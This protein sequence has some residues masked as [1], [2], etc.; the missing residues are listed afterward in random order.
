MSRSL[1]CVVWAVWSKA[2]N[3]RKIRLHSAP[4]KWQASPSFVGRVLVGS[5]RIPICHR[6]LEVLCPAYGWGP[7]RRRLPDIDAVEIV[8]VVR[9]RWYM[10]RPSLSIVH[11]PGSDTVDR[12]STTSCMTMLSEVAVTC[13][14]SMMFGAGDFNI[15]FDRVDVFHVRHRSIWSR[16]SAWIYLWQ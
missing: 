4:C 16:A 1:S 9:A 11:R 7:S 13:D 10:R 12:H 15:R 8:N 3:A 6:S 5:V 2:H 14:V